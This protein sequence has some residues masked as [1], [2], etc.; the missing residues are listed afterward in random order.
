METFSIIHYLFLVL[1]HLILNQLQLETIIM[2]ESIAMICY[3]SMVQPEEIQQTL[4][5][6]SETVIEV[7][8]GNGGGE[9]E[10]EPDK[11]KRD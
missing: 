4:F 8:T 10:G 7:Y 1:L 5:E 3:L 11:K 9:P 6:P 2:F